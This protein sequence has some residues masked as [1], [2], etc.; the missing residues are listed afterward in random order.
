M[1][2]IQ[3][4]KCS[5]G[6]FNL[7]WGIIFK[8]DFSLTI[9][10]GVANISFGRPMTSSKVNAGTNWK[11]YINKLNYSDI[12]LRCVYG[13]QK[14]YARNNLRDGIQRRVV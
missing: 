9:K 12:I 3:K 5:F 6:N 4:F 7:L 8:N 11:I 1:F 13:R 2:F 10:D 14:S